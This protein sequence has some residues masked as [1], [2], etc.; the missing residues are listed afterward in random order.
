MVVFLFLVREQNGWRGYSRRPLFRSVTQSSV[1]CGSSVQVPQMLSNIGVP[2][3]TSPKTRNIGSK[4]AKYWP[5]LI[6]LEIHCKAHSS[7]CFRLR[8]FL[9]F[10]I[11]Y[12]IGC[13]IFFRRRRNET[14]KFTVNFLL[15][16]L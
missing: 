1:I 6:T 12:L 10:V 5:T 2:S 8:R 7:G 11:S 4:L 13:L 16:Y 15:N 14:E 9:R 3:I